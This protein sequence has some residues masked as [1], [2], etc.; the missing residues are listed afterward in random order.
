MFD[1]FSLKCCNYETPCGSCYANRSWSSLVSPGCRCC[2][3]GRR[4]VVLKQR[5]S[6][7]C[8]TI[9]PA[10]QILTAKTLFSFSK[11]E[12]LTTLDGASFSGRK[13]MNE[14]C[15]CDKWNF[16]SSLGWGRPELLGNLEK[17]IN[18]PLRFSLRLEWS[19]IFHLFQS[20]IQ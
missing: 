1:L 4:W 3:C 20:F 2:C 13:R 11:I 12:C 15:T 18:F 10:S 17:M 19:S 14:L 7:T 8:Q 5:S 6:K 16:G 9:F